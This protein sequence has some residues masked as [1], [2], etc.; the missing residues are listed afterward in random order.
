MPVDWAVNGDF[1][2]K[3]AVYV[4][5]PIF[6]LSKFRLASPDDCSRTVHHSFIER[7]CRE[8]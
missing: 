4:R 5:W 3:N 2:L 7:R 6:L 1:V 8:R